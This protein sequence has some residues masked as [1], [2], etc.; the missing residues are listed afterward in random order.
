[1]ED[2]SI[3]ELLCSGDGLLLRECLDSLPSCSFVSQSHNVHM[4][5]LPSRSARHV[6]QLVMGTGTAFCWFAI[7]GFC[8]NTEYCLQR[9]LRNGTQISPSAQECF[10][11]DKPLCR[12]RSRAKRAHSLHKLC[13]G[14]SRYILLLWGKGL[15]DGPVARALRT[16]RWMRYTSK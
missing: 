6:G 2:P 10:V 8:C 5:G 16:R 12:F 11:N 9:S 4:F 7:S 13:G 1:M 14:S 3:V 15:G